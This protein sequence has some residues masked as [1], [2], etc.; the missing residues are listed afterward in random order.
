MTTL[1]QDC[2]NDKLSVV[3]LDR[4][5]RELAR[6]LGLILGG[7]LTRIC[8]AAGINR[9]QV[10]ERERQ[11]LEA[12]D[13]VELAGAGRPASRPACAAPNP[14]APQ[15]RL[16]EQVLRFRLE[17]PGALVPHAGGHATYSDGFIRFVLDLHDDWQGTDEGFCVWA[18]IPCQTLRGWIGRDGDQP[19]RERPSLALPAMAESA[20]GVA[21]RIAEDYAA[22]QGSLRDFFKYESAR[23]QLAPAAIRR[24]LAI[25]GMIGVR[26]GKGPRY[27]GSTHLCLPG[28]V[29]VTDGK[30]VTAVCTGTGEIHTYNWQ[31]IVDQATVCHTATVVTRT[32]SAEGVGRAFD[33]SCAFLGRPPVALLHDNKPIHDDVALREHV[34]KTTLMIPATPGRG[35]NKAAIEGE[36]GKFEQ[37]VGTIYLDDSSLERLKES[38]VCEVLRAYTAGLNHAGRAEL[39][40]KSREQVLRET[41]PD[42]EKDRE[43]IATLH[44]DHTKKRRCDLL[45]TKPISRA[46]LDEGFQRFGIADRDP[47]G[48]LREWLAGRY[49]PEA[50]RQGLAIFGVEREKRRL[51]GAHTHR[52]LVKVIQNCKHEIDLRRQEELLREFA[53]VER[54]A[55]LRVYGAEYEALC[56][57]CMGGSAATD[58]A[59]RL[60][61]NAVFGG[62]ILQR[63]FWENKLKELLIKERQKIAAVCRHVHR[64]LEATWENRFALIG[65]LTAWEY[66]L[67]A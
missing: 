18:E 15:W 14:E 26:S 12:M 17:H 21:R 28:T 2:R 29:L 11:L 3:A 51:R 60:A 53:E 67:S 52:Y 34:E 35:E 50:I 6:E 27:R 5:V 22:W 37:T 33:E 40:G 48:S 13:K 23:L 56:A 62:L 61:E 43:F 25:F 7:P 41:C 4:I 65:K 66:Q 31:G 10:Y 58:L 16:R 8:E 19:Y 54:A 9:T 49:A 44:A 20:N 63:A 36:F 42:P 24:V 30:D 47:K 59:L 32:E 38:A 57:Q 64:L 46:L 55:W 1:I 39:D 45:P